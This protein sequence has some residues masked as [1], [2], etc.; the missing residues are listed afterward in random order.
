MQ[1]ASDKQATSFTTNTQ[2]LM[3]NEPKEPRKVYGQCQSVN[4][5]GVL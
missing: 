5:P 4:G 1:E 2:Q 3:I